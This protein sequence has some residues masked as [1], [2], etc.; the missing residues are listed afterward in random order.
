MRALL[1]LAAGFLPVAAQIPPIPG[2]PKELLRM[3]ILDIS[4]GTGAEARAGQQYTVHY[5]GWLRDGKKFDSSKDRNEPLQFV[6]GRRLVIAGWEAGF[7]GMRVGGKRRLISPYQM[8]YGERGSGAT[9]PPK[10]ELTFDVELL[11]VTDV[12][13]TPAASDILDPLASLE[14]KFVALAEALPEDQYNWRPAAGVRSFGEVLQHVKQDNVLWLKLS[15]KIPAAEELAKLTSEAG[16]T[17]PSSK[18]S[19]IQGLKQSFVDLQKAIEPMRA[20]TLAGNVHVFGRDMT[21]RAVFVLFIEHAGE[22]LGQ[23]IA[24]ERSNGI[25]PP[26]SK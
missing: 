12:P 18:A 22:H 5:T 1:F 19:T 9:I 2:E 21:R 8:A 17:E 13:E 16:K 4:Q 24:Y 6:Q 25:V 20:G 23:L 7:E 15:G 11:A 10:A 26:W 3:T 14:R